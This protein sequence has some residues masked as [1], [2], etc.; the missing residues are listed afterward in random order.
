MNDEEIL[1]NRILYTFNGIAAVPRP[2]GHESAI[3]QYLCECLRGHSL[4]PVIDGARNVL[5]DV[6]ATKGRE[7]APLT[8]LQ[9]HTDMVC[10][11]KNEGFDFLRE[12]I[13]TTVSGEW[14]S[15]CGT[16]LGADDG[17]GI[18][19]ALEAVFSGFPHGPLRLIF[20][21]DEEAGMSGVN[22]LAA[23]C[24]C[25]ARYLIN[26]D[27]ER[28]GTVCISSAGGVKAVYTRDNAPRQCA[29]TNAVRISVSGLAGGHSAEYINSGRLNAN[30]A[31]G[32]IL[33]ALQASGL[34][35]ELASLDGGVFPNS[36]PTEA[37][38][39]VCLD[40]SD[41]GAFTSAYEA[42]SKVLRDSFCESESGIMISCEDAQPPQSVMSECDALALIS[43]LSAA[44]DGVSSMSQRNPELVQSSSNCGIVHANAEHTSCTVFSRSSSEYWLERYISAHR[45]LAHALGF[46]LDARDVAA[47]WPA[48]PGSTLERYFCEAFEHISGRQARIVATHGGLEC[49]SFVK[50]NPSLEI[51]AV[52]P[53]IENAHSTDERLYIPSLAPTLK[54]VCSVLAKIAVEKAE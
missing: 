44:P 48:K 8:V 7:K 54:T 31:V 47:A 36:I 14:L 49:G 38:A 22:A 34:D 41:K 19:L 53:T 16:T 46:Q 29:K 20:T 37:A 17:I 5:C 40:L 30:C 3:A 51:A 13:K 2:S 1:T 11:A 9:A 26:L 18:A 32:H 50:L 35:F 33:S 4:S 43:L 27:E 21:A 45:S 23:D 6:P 28:E 15:A 42:A 39:V 24:V 12:P 52:G 25:G 10:V